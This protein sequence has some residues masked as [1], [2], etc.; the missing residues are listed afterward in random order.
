LF[1]IS[2]IGPIA[3]CR[4]TDGELRRNGRIRVL[5]NQQVIADSE[6]GSLKHLQEDAREVRQGFECGVSLKGF[7]D[8]EVGDLL[9]CYIR[10]QVLI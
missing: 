3:G 9:E 1:R 4:V 5:R 7:T 10:E 2:K 6:I 8:F